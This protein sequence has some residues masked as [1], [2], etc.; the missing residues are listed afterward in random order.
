MPQQFG[1]LD[2]VHPHAACF[3]YRHVQ[4]HKL[5]LILQDQH[6]HF[7]HVLYVKDSRLLCSRIALLCCSRPDTGTGTFARCSVQAAHIAAAC[8]VWIVYNGKS[9]YRIYKQLCF[10]LR[11]IVSYLCHLGLSKSVKS[12]TCKS[13]DAK[14]A[15]PMPPCNM[16]LRW[17]RSP[18]SRNTRHCQAVYLH[19][20][21]AANCCCCVCCSW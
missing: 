4:V 1:T 14:P 7:V 6:C 9:A 16:H 21:H 11:L 20:H 5:V 15:G 3:T 18:C 17:Q 13:S 10:L 2:L 19:H 8:Q 12:R